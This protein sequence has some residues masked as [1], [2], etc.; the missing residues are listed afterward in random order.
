M[1]EH[2]RLPIHGSRAHVTIEEIVIDDSPAKVEASGSHSSAAEAAPAE[3]SMRA[4]AMAARDGSAGPAGEDSP[5]PGQKLPGASFLFRQASLRP[6]EESESPTND[7]DARVRTASGSGSMLSRGMSNYEG[8]RL[9]VSNRTQSS[10]DLGAAL[11]G[12]AGSVVS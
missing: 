12:Y 5:M 11:Y 1:L 3:G 4:A 9:M 10:V 8:R 2:Q 7:G 6:H